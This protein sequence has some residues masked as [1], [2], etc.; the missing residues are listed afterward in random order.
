[1]SYAHA[2]S[3]LAAGRFH[4]KVIGHLGRG[5]FGQVDEVVITESNSAR[6][7]G[8]HYARKRLNEA[9][10]SHPEARERFERE[11]V[12]LRGMRDLSGIVTYRGENV[13]GEDTFYIMDVYPRSLR[14]FLAS[15]PD[16]RP[17]R[18]VARFCASIART[19]AKAHHRGFIHRD[20]KPEN[21]LLTSASRPI[22]VDWGLG[23]FMH[24]ASKVLVPLTRGGMGT[25]YYCS[26][27]QW[28]TGQC[29]Q[30]GDIY[31]LGMLIGELA[32]GSQVPIAYQG[33]G[34]R[35]GVT[36]ESSL[37]AVRLGRFVR[38]M[39]EVL[40]HERPATMHD[41]AAGLEEALEY[42]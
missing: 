15:N 5:G 8:A 28:A 33:A 41:V 2:H 11:I 13:P 36:N 21:I 40:A 35:V 27:E 1:M 42:D 39:T 34:I 23:R 18:E 32:N 4:F 6:P 29:D 14:Q 22:I 19:M 3:A 30:R 9:F 24:Q 20:L 38:Q 12:Q 37:G 16:G 31:S 7:V 26:M 17:W 10:N 25:E